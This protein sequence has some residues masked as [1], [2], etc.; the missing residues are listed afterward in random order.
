MW[1]LT[2]QPGLNQHHYTSE[3]KIFTTGRPWKFLQFFLGSYSCP[4]FAKL[5]L[6]F[7]EAILF[8][9]SYLIWTSVSKPHREKSGSHK[10]LTS[11]LLLLHNT[12]VPQIKSRWQPLSNHPYEEKWGNEGAKRI[13]SGFLWANGVQ[14]GSPTSG[15][16]YLMIWAG[17]DGII[18]KSTISVMCLNHPEMMDDPCLWSMEKFSSTKMVPDAKRVEDHWH[19]EQT[20]KDSWAST[21][22]GDLHPDKVSDPPRC[23][24][25]AS[26]SHSVMSDSLLP[27][28]L[29]PT[30]LLCPWDS[31]GKNTGVGCHALLQR[32]FLTQGLKL[33]HRQILSIWAT[34]KTKSILT[35]KTREAVDGKV[36][37][38]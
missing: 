4:V 26:V 20:L 15:I 31:S 6:V 10:Q 16:K 19:R 32:I 23:T 27:H 11:L 21:D 12:S 24:E 37:L 3:G 18:I 25:S 36:P 7:M 28:E 8:L 33:H 38:C 9:R 14:Q 5:K 29:W 22:Q 35:R 30:S 17:A 34:R 13:A 1:V 2:L